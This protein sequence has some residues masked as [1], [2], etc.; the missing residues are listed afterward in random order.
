MHGLTV[1][2]GVALVIV[3]VILGRP[4][5]RARRRRAWRADGLA[6]TAQKMLFRDLEFYA[7][8][9]E[10]LR[11]RLD[12]QAR[13]FLEEKRFIGC[14]DMEVTADMKVCI[15]AQ[16]ALLITNRTDCYDDLSEVLVYPA[17]FVTRRAVEDENGLISQ[18]DAELAGE[19]WDRG[20]VVLSWD[21]SRRGAAD[22]DDGVNVVVHE[23]AHQLDH[24]SGDTDGMPYMQDRELAL[25]W[26]GVMNAA[27]DAHCARVDAGEVDVIDEYASTDPAEFFAVATE[28]FIERPADLS[29]R[30]ADVYSVLSE[31]YGL[32][33][34]AWTSVDRPGR[35]H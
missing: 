33:P 19:S 32:D 5:L 9:P 2:F 22:L 25:R 28:T 1:I 8:L 17:A 20:Q 27:Y 34:L 35:L 7:R 30:Y 4:M 18:E 21:D 11:R 13:V 23:F 3:A 31:L 12:G 14:H 24:A 16:A 10:E 26:L 15:A 29:E 6:L